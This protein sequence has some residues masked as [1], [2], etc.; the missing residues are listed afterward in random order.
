MKKRQIFP[1]LLLH[2]AFKSLGRPTLSCSIS[3]YTGNLSNRNL[4]A[5][6]SNTHKCSNTLRLFSYRQTFVVPR[7][8]RPRLGSIRPQLIP[9]HHLRTPKYIRSPHNSRLYFRTGPFV[10]RRKRS[11]IP[12]AYVVKCLT[13]RAMCAGIYLNIRRWEFQS[14]PLF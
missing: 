3:C 10:I 6:M 14:T 4:Y 9:F 12:L 13:S 7:K 11:L 5:H 1:F 2:H 8:H